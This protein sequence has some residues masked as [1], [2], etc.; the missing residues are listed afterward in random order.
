[1][2]L[3]GS[4]QRQHAERE[5]RDS[6]NPREE[7]DMPVKPTAKGGKV[8]KVTRREEEAE[9]E[10]EEIDVEQEEAEEEE[11]VDEED[12]GGEGTETAA[13]APAGRK[14]RP[15]LPRIEW[16]Q[17]MD[18]VLAVT[19]HK[20]QAAGK[21]TADKVVSLLSK[22]PLFHE[23]ADRLSARVVVSRNA[24][25]AKIKDKKTGKTINIPVLES[26]QR[27]RYDV[28]DFNSELAKLLAE[29]EG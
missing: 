5:K 18:M 17:P 14:G 3:L 16:T 20:L 27:K 8:N 21:L 24:K 26:V 1:M 13:E 2:T 19:L 29:D 23:I 9:E 12:D 28:E 15:R 11:E 6:A 10:D 4:P 7:I 22:H 25:L